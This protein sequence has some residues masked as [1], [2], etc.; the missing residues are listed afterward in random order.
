MSR[1]I[2]HDG[3]DRAPLGPQLGIRRFLGSRPISGRVGVVRTGESLIYGRDKGPQDLSLGHAARNR[4]PVG[5]I[6]LQRLAPVR[7]PAATPRIPWH[8]QNLS[9]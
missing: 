2:V 5:R 7:G 4:S 1:Q 3:V 6:P 8:S 9:L